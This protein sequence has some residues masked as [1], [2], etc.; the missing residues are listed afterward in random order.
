M[1][2]WPALGQLI[3][4]HQGSQAIMADERFLG[5]ERPEGLRV[6]YR[7]YFMSRSG[8]DPTHIDGLYTELPLL[9]DRD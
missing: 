6:P 9:Y 2:Y 8:V 3:V 4:R 7:S 5:P 1:Q